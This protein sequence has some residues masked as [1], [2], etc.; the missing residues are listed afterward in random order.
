MASL[1]TITNMANWMRP[2]LKMQPLA[3]TNN[4]PLLTTANMVLQ[5]LLSPPLSWRFNQGSFTFDCVLTPAPGQFDYALVL[6]DFGFLQDQWIIDPTTKDVMPLAGMTS[7][8]RP[9]G[10]S[11]ARPSALAPQNDDNLGNI[12]FRLKEI[13]NKAYTVAG[14][15]Q[16]KAPLLTSPAQ[17]FS[18]FPDEFSFVY[19]WG[20]LAVMSLLVNDSRFP[21]FNQFFLSRL[22]ALQS[23]LDEQAKNLFVGNWMA[24][25]GTVAKAQSD[26][27][28]NLTGGR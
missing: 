5:T 28:R 18:P 11:K 1:I 25:M 24:M 20:N 21:I 13:P 19:G 3:V 7:L 10:M 27:T 15:Y 12:T 23:G 6:P 8:A 17:T 2:I 14:D 22:L 9:T 4:E 16:K 26:S